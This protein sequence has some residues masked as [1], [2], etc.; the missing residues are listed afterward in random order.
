[1]NWRVIVASV[2]L[3]TSAFA[4]SRT[5][6]RLNEKRGHHAGVPGEYATYADLDASIEALQQYLNSHDVQLAQLAD[7]D[8][9]LALR[10]DAIEHISPSERLVAIE[11][12]INDLLWL[13]SVMV[14]GII[15]IAGER[16]H[17]YWARRNG[18]R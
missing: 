12:K 5:D 18:K 11:T 1:M 16:F 13:V 7:A 3:T 15:G 8:K 2:A 6:W 10:L 4:Q 14:A 17:D 9:V